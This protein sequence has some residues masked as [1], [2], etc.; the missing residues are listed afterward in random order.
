M[1][2]LAALYWTPGLLTRFKDSYGYELVP[3]LPLLFSSVNTWNG[4]LPVYNVSYA[5]ENDTNVKDSVHQI[6]YRKVLNDGYQDYLSQFRE[7]SH[8][9]GTEYSAQPA[10]NLPLQMVIPSITFLYV[11][12]ATDSGTVQ[13]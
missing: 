8:T 9:V 5:F 2:I 7:W 6:D 12:I 13:R 11:D 1:E 3:Y 4:F 10:Y